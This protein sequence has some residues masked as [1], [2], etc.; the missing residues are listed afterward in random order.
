MARLTDPIETN[1][2]INIATDLPPTGLYPGTR[3]HSLVVLYN[4]TPVPS[5]QD[6]RVLVHGHPT[7]FSIP[8]SQA[9]VR[10]SVDSHVYQSLPGRLS[11]LRDLYLRRI[12]TRALHADRSMPVPLPALPSQSAGQRPREKR[13]DQRQQCPVDLLQ[14]V[15]LHSHRSRLASLDMHLLFH[16]SILHLSCTD[17]G[18]VCHRYRLSALHPS[19]SNLLLFQI[20]SDGRCQVQVNRFSIAIAGARRRHH[21]ALQQSA[22][23][24][25]RDERSGIAASAKTSSSEAQTTDAVQWQ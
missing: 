8:F 22:R 9:I 21:H 25:Q 14:H 13:F 16:A 6:Q 4:P 23:V 10:A 17:R 2:T 11:I 15:R 19:A 12:R 24:E 7:A 3:R 20:E 1:E 18:H 5:T